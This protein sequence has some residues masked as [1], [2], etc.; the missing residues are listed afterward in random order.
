MVY[1]GTIFFDGFNIIHKVCKNSKELLKYPNI[2]YKFKE[3]KHAQNF[4]NKDINYRK[5]FNTIS[6]DKIY[7]DGSYKN[8]VCGSSAIILRKDEDIDIIYQKVPKNYTQNI[9]V[10]ELYG[11]KIGIEASLNNCHFFTDSLNSIKILQYDSQFKLNDIN[12]I[13]KL[14]SNIKNNMTDKNILF[15]YIPSNYR[16]IYHNLANN[17]ARIAIKEQFKN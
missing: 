1:F 9:N 8:N 11:I 13:N 10:A 15:S 6:Y 2:H 5:Y 12:S 17:Y 14:V 3:L 7:T 16:H 4:I